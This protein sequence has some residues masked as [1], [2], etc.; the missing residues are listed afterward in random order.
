MRQ[1]KIHLLQEV[2]EQLIKLWSDFEGDELTKYTPM[3]YPELK[4]NSILFVGINPSF[5]AAAVIRSVKKNVALSNQFQTIENV[6]D[7]HLFKQ[8]KVRDIIDILAEIQNCHRQELPYFNRHKILANEFSI[9]NWE[10]IDLFQIRHS[11]QNTVMAAFK[12][13]S[14][15][16]FFKTQIELFLNLLKIYSPKS[17]IVLN[18]KSSEIIKKE[19][20]KNDSC[21]LT[22]I[23]SKNE[24]NL[25]LDGIQI[26]V[27]FS[28]HDQYKSAKQKAVIKAEIG[29]F[30]QSIG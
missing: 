16:L 7:F 3:F 20:N 1:V 28:V 12:K 14:E 23:K 22:L 18:S 19:F 4:L 15:N 13:N 17:I 29:E 26:P 27:L 8:E 5:N 9:E 2:N 21:I 24:Y 10:Q 11:N 6:D 25:S 30:I